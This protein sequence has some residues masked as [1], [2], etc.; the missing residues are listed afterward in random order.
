M[1]TVRCGARKGGG[2]GPTGEG[3]GPAR[4]MLTGGEM[5]L[6]I[7]HIKQYTG[8]GGAGRNKQP[9]QDI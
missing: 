9:K 5:T 8:R 3:S 7:M 2:G 4:A 6:V 1:A